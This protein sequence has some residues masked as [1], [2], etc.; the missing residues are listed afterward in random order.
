MILD[1]KSLLLTTFYT[2]SMITFLKS[3]INAIRFQILR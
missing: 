2:L 1:S 3:N